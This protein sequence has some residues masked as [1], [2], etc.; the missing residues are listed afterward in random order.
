MP[1]DQNFVESAQPLKNDNESEEK[2]NKDTARE[3]LKEFAS[4][5]FDEY[6]HSKEVEESFL[7]RGYSLGLSTSIISYEKVDIYKEPK[8]PRVNHDQCV[9][10]VTVRLI[11]PESSEAKFSVYYE[12]NSRVSSADHMIGS[13]E[14]KKEF[15]LNDKEKLMEQVKAYVEDVITKYSPDWDHYDI[16]KWR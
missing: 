12:V 4:K 15:E 8:D 14:G 10:A 5:Y 7:K 16:Y 11:N 9:G 3:N 13:T 1:G 6:F 2:N